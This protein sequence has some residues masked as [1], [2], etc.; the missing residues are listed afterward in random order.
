[1]KIQ[2]SF[3]IPITFIVLCIPLVWPNDAPFI[4]DEPKFFLSA[5]DANNAHKLAEA[6]FCGNVGLPYGPVST[7]IYQL[8]ISITT[9]PSYW[10]FLRAGFVVVSIALGLFLLA[11]ATG[12]WK[13]FI[14]IALVSPYIW[15]F[16]RHLWDNSFLLAFSSLAIGSYAYFLSLSTPKTEIEPEEKQYDKPKEHSHEAPQTCN[17]CKLNKLSKTKSIISIYLPGM[18]LL[19]A[20]AIAIIMPF[21]HFMSLAFSFTLL[22][23]MCIYARKHLRKILLPAVVISGILLYNLTPYFN[24]LLNSIRNLKP[25][26]VV[27]TSE[28]WKG[29]V[30]PL[31]GGRLLSAGGL[32][33]FFG[34]N[35]LPGNPIYLILE[36]ITYFGYLLVLI[37]IFIAGKI[38]W[39]KR[40]MFVISKSEQ[41]PF[42]TQSHLSLIALVSLI[43]QILICGISRSY[44][45][46]HY[47][48]GIWIT[49]AILAWIATDQIIKMKWGK[50]FVSTYGI[51]LATILLI[52]ITLVHQ[53]NGTRGFY[54]G[55]TIGNQW[56]ITRKIGLSA[57]TDVKCTV[58]N[59]IYFPSILALHRICLKDDAD[60]MKGPLI[61]EYAKKDPLSGLVR[62]RK[63]SE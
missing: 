38:V 51:S 36:G 33:Y 34:N 8:L 20:F 24:I 27:A 28:F 2:A 22:L 42:E 49:H 35:W 52:I 60:R 41:I 58:Q 31:F 9:V 59:F 47:H 39:Q 4:N 11:R 29:W 12:W 50:I 43:F 32:N 63:E 19:L 30:F 37:G 23:H 18:T 13:W 21:V 17:D 55:P 1:M 53:R 62:I 40:K 44:F 7:W 25:Q 61:I 46:P 48:N 6:G 10:V 45:H 5:F 57:R 26:D 3:Y 16:S 56:E 15:F 14:P 54:Y